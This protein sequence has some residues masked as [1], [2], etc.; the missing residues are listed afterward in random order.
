MANR[1][2]EFARFDALVG[3]VL[4]VPKLILDQRLKD[5]REQARAA[6]KRPTPKPKKTR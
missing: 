6:K 2:K 1:S 3:K 4:G 5:E